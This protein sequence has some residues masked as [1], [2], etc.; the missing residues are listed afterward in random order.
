VSVYFWALSANLSYAV[1]V[2]FLARYARSISSMWMNCFKALFACAAFLLWVLLVEGFH[3][4]D[5]RAAGAFALSGALGLGLA[6]AFSLKAFAVMGPGRTLLL[7]GFQPLLLGVLGPA[8]LGQ[9]ADPRRWTA[10]GFFIACL[11]VFSV[12]SWKRSGRWEPRALLYALSGLCLDTCGLIIT[13]LS[14]D[15]SPGITTMEG[16]LYRGLGAVLF[17]GVVSRIRPFDFR[18]RWRSLRLRDRLWV[19]LGSFLAT[20]LALAFYLQA[21]RQ[22]HLATISA[23]GIT[24]VML[25]AGLECGLERRA[26]SKYLVAAFALFL[27]GMAVLLRG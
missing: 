7:Y 8:W 17:M 19:S 22:G 2:Q 10:I 27:G 26:P 23:I 18:G 11:A 15:H 13:R 9:E 5:P 21:V 1:G 20:F 12:E 24:G 3:P 14:F 16:N 6:D 25:A 4:I